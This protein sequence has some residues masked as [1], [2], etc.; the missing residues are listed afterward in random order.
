MDQSQI[1]TDPHGA[2][3]ASGGGVPPA[4]G[5]LSVDPELHGERVL[6]RFRADVDASRR[7]AARDPANAVWQ[8]GLRQSLEEAANAM[9]KSGDTAG[10]KAA[11][12]EAEIAARTPTAE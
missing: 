11:R 2:T 5:L 12:D 4:T 9:E 10:A 1:E 6:L 7:L 8:T 3:M